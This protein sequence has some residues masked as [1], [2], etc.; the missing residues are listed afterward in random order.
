[1]ILADTSVWAQHI[2]AANEGLGFALARGTIVIHEFVL[3]ELVLGHIKGGA[4]METLLF[5][6]AR[7]PAASTEQVLDFVRAHKLRGA[8]I[9]WTD[10]HLLAAAVTNG[11]SLWTFDKALASQALR[12]GVAWPRYSPQNRLS[13]RED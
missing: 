10:A 13:P 2:R 4:T 9:G 8:G 1:M 6:L 11:L 5:A 12:L 7:L 3:G